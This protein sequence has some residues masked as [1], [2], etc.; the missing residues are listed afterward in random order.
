VRML[1]WREADAQASFGAR[2]EAK[3]ASREHARSPVGTRFLARHE[4]VLA[5]AMV[6][7]QVL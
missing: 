1:R 3:A 6:G 5:M 7:A 4:T 2:G